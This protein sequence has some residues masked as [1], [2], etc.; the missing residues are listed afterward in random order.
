M[1]KLFT[2]AAA[3]CVAIGATLLMTHAQSRPA[4][5]N[6]DD[7]AKTA[8]QAAPAEATNANAS[9]LDAV[10]R[11][12]QEQQ[13]EIE[14]LRAT[15]TEQAKLLSDLLSRSTQPTATSSAANVREATYTIDGV[16]A[17]DALATRA[18]QT[19]SGGPTAKNTQTGQTIEARVH[20]L[21]DQS[22]KS[23]ESLSKLGS[24]NFSGDVRLRYETQFGLL[25]SL[26]NAANPAIVG[27]ELSDRN[28]ARVRARLA[29]RGEI[30]KRFDW[31]IRLATGTTPDIVST[32]QTLTDF[33]GR[34]SFAVDQAFISYKPAAVRGL[35]L[36]GGK[37]ETPWLFTEMTIDA[38][39]MPEGLNETYSRDL[40]RSG[41]LKNLTFVAW[42][43]PMLERAPGF[44]LGGGGKLDAEASRRAG[45]DLALYGA[46]ARARLEPTKHT[47]LTVSAADLNFN[48]TQFIIPAQVFGSTLQ[49]PITFTI[50][51]TSTTAAQTITTNVSIPRDLLVNGSS[52]GVSVGSTNATNRDG[53]LSSGYNLVDL[54]SRFEWTRSRRFPVTALLDFV[55]NTQAHAVVTSTGALSNHENR[56]LWAELQVGKTRARGDYLFDYTFLRIERDAVLAP[57][58]FSDIVQP[59]DVRAHRFIASYAVDPRIT[60]TVTAV[61]SQRPN[62]LL[63]AFGTTPAGSLNRPTTRL[64]FDTLFRF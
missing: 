45:R 57:F 34:K 58:N 59:T 19:Q 30:G 41:P 24:I 10:R 32:N 28:R 29:L 15:L 21:E 1:P 54:I 49:V 2:R 50:P 62:G 60:L 18:Q 48:G 27:N 6:S 36:Q 31:G 3:I 9:S 5:T 38:D 56:G 55:N 16:A 42:Q 61:V 11:Q 23:G 43:L 13:A 26:P 47:A 33:F 64:Q 4:P 25:N 51:A 8:S 39:L 17:T 35:R 52:L 40:K 63:G 22:K 53:H 37:F 14:R 20:A 46:Q 12:L 7:A 44:V